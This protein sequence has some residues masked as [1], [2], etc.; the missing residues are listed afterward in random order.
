MNNEYWL[1]HILAFEDFKQIDNGKKFS[2]LFIFIFR[3][4]NLSFIHPDMR[5]YFILSVIQ[6]PKGKGSE[7][8]VVIEM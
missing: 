1:V 2:G 8:Q 4:S 7:T 3:V 6:I 5:L